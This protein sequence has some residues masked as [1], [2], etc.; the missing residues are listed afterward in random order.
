M[1]ALPHNLSPQELA[2]LL[3]EPDLDPVQYELRSIDIDPDQPDTDLLADRLEGDTRWGLD[4]DDPY[5]W[6]A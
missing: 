1:P 2:E 3:A 5:R 4:L 6:A